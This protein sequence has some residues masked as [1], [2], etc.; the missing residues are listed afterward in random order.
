MEKKKRLYKRNEI[1]INIINKNA[2]S[3]KMLDATLSLPLRQGCMS[4]DDFLTLLLLLHSQAIRLV[5]L[6]VFLLTLITTITNT[7][8]TTKWICS[9]FDHLDTITAT[10]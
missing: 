7:T 2:A 6:P 3:E 9:V 10:Y 1:T 4:S 5:P 8:T